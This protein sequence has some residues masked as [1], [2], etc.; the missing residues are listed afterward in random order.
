[1]SGG[2]TS[3]SRLLRQLRNVASL[4]QEELAERAGLSARGISDLERGLRQAPRPET[5]R[6]LADALAL[7]EGDRAALLA[8]ARPA[9]LHEGGVERAQPA[10]VLLPV[11]LTRLI[12]RQDE[13]AA[14]QKMIASHDG[15][16][17]TITG[18]GGTGKTRL[19]LEVAAT[20]IDHYVDGVIFVDLSPLTDPGLVIPTI[21]AALGVH[22]AAGRPLFDTLASVLAPKRLLLILDNCE[23]VLAA[24]REITTLVSGSPGLTILGTSREPLHARGEREFPLLPLPLPATDYLP[25]SAELA[26]IP[27]IAL[28]VERATESL[29]DFALTTDNASSVAA[30][31]QRLDGL[32]LAIELAAA[33]VKVLP[34]TAMLARLEQR[35]PLLTGGGRDLPERQRTMRDAIAWSYDLLAPEEQTLFRRLAVFA[36]GFTLASAEA[37][38][39]PEGDHSVLDGV[40]ALVEQSLL[41]QAPSTDEGPR[42]LMLETVREF[43]L[44][45]LVVAGEEDNARRRHAEHF[46][47][48]SNDA[49]HGIHILED[50]ESLSPFLIEQD[51]MRLALTWFEDRGE[52]EAL[53]RLSAIL[54][55]LWFQRGLYSEVLQWVEHALQQSTGVVS[56]S[57]VQA[58]NGAGMLALFQGDYARAARCF[59]EALVVA[60][61]L[62]DAVLVGHAM[63]YAALVSYRRREFD[64]AADLL[65][66]AHRLL[67]GSSSASFDNAQGAMALHA[68]GDVA[69]AQG[70]FDQAAIHYGEAIDLLHE[71]RYAW[72][73]SDAQAGLAGVHYCT[74]DFTQAAALYEE[75]VGRSHDINLVPLLVSALLGLAG[76]AAE[77]G[78]LETGAR[79]FGAAEGIAETLGM[80]IFPRDLPVRNRSLTR[81][82]SALGEKSLAATRVTGRKMSINEAIAEAQRVADAVAATVSAECG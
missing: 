68:L 76:I 43:G 56:V 38:A 70:Q 44:E 52:S 65:H 55:A 41:R 16:L 20:M 71:T 14:L 30:I 37:V 69:L 19:A 58:L 75:S 9:V 25:A 31:C 18:P 22:E 42:Y 40:V 21:A 7:S 48:L 78:H 2:M 77:T 53:L 62:G 6:L 36:G 46:L 34:P 79:L 64:R 28:F 66:Q 26:H 39:D 45:R 17:V 3:F 60:R 72:G 23:R 50:V 8:A 54:S 32:P 11:P 33:R 15:R 59:D 35:L 1:M 10:L 80:P 67:I 47:T 63:N 27:A 74:G 24:A 4:S 13:L 5:V 12:G 81:L 29:P 49:I 73:L 51:N 57:R 82:T 61:A